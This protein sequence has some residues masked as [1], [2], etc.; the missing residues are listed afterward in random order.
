MY[1]YLLYFIFRKFNYKLGSIVD[2]G[3]PEESTET[4]NFGGRSGRMTMPSK[5]VII[6]VVLSMTMIMAAGC[7]GWGT[8]GPTESEEEADGN[9]EAQADEGSENEDSDTTTDGTS[10]GE[11]DERAEAPEDTLSTVEEET[12]A[13]DST[14]SSDTDTQAEGSES[15]ESTDETESTGEEDSQPAES[16]GADEADEQDDS[17]DSSES[18]TYTLTVTVESP[19]GHN[20]EGADVSVVT[21]DGGEPVDSAATDENGQATFEVENGDYEVSVGGTQFHQS[22]DNRL[23]TVNG[24]DTAFDVN[25]QNP[26]GMYDYS[27]TVQVVDEDGNP[28]ANELVRIGTPGEKLEKHITDENGEVTISFGN[29]AEDDAVM[30]TIEVR[31]EE[32][33]ASITLGEQTEQIVVS[34]DS[35]R[36]THELTVHAGE[37][38]PVENVDVTIERWDGSTTTKTTGENGQVTFTVYPGEYTVTGSDERGEEQTVAVSVP[39]QQDV[40]LDQMGTPVPEQVT[41]TLDVVD[42]DGEP[43]EGVTVEAMTSIPPTYADVYIQ[44]EPTDENG[45]ATVEAHA[46]QTYSID[47]V[48]DSAGNSYSVQRVGDGQTLHIEEDGTA[49][50]IVVERSENDTQQPLV[51]A[52]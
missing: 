46:G 35:E 44:S 23:V 37:R 24:E 28:V 39:D 32:Y 27:M 14:E 20:V 1:Y 31:D 33:S 8:N 50:T 47:R 52:A 51:V 49:D 2:Y 43:V 21:Y 5:N 15:K 42:Q 19:E 40:L 38:A 25:M 26:D 48:V 11:E 13:Q 9:G 30:Q 6:A 10:D 3:M 34:D 16:N 4:S 45:Q 7:A 29:S 17:D 12:G 18:E 36:E 41:T 22:S